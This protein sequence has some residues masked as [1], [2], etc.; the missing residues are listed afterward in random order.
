M[1]S[2]SSSILTAIKKC[3]QIKK[4]IKHSP[5]KSCRWES[6]WYGRTD[7][8]THDEANCSLS[9]LF[10]KSSNKQMP[11]LISVLHRLPNFTLRPLHPRN[12]LGC[13]LNRRLGGPYSWCRCFGKVKS[14]RLCRDSNCG[15]SN[16]RLI[17]VSTELA[18]NIK[19]NK[20]YILPIPSIQ[21]LF[22]FF[23]SFP[24]S[25]TFP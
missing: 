5:L 9:R 21:I 4:E 23:S 13:P 24:P 16:S 15:P 10:V 8:Q 19:I 17:I 25:F 3:R 20:S 2:D 11:F 22:S 18:R 6:L 7:R 1:K 14:S 12:E